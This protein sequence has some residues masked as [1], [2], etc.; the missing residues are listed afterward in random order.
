LEKDERIIGT[1]GARFGTLVVQVGA[2]G[3]KGL[4]L[5]LNFYLLLSFRE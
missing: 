2:Q 1:T 5:A 4:V 3:E